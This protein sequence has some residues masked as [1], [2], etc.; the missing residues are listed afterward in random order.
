MSIGLKLII[1]MGTTLIIST[2]LMVDLNIFRMRGLLD[3][4]LL[5][6]ALPASRETITN[7]VE[8]DLQALI[9]ASKLIANTVTLKIGLRQVSPYRA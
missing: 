1:G 3:R 6:S 9:T 8:R 5:N 2:L 4:Y 7:A